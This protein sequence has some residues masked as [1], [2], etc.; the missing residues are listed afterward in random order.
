MHCKVHRNCKLHFK[1]TLIS[2]N[3]LFVYYIHRHTLNHHLRIIFI[4]YSKTSGV[5][6]KNS[7]FLLQGPK[8]QSALEMLGNVQFLQG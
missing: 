8:N 4:H 3:L 6:I 1:G 5:I 7:A 2:L